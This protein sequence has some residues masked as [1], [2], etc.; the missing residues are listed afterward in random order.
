MH[1]RNSSIFFRSAAER[2]GPPNALMPAPP[3]G[4]AGAWKVC[5]PLEL[6][7]LLP[8]SAIET[9]AKPTAVIP[10]ATS[11]SPRGPSRIVMR[12][13]FFITTPVRRVPGVTGI[14]D[15]QASPA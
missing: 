12:R 7:L 5:V 8:L 14:A 10:A 1:W 2:F 3:P 6:L 4:G 15:H 11:D 13:L 9:A